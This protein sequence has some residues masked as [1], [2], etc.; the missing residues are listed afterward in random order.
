MTTTDRHAVDEAAVAAFAERIFGLYRDGLLV[1]MLDLGHRTGLF[2]AAASGPATSEALASRAGLDERYVREWL[3]AMATAGIVEYEPAAG[4]YRLPAEH[5]VCLTGGGSANLAP[6]AQ[7]I[8]HLAKHVGQ[9]AEA[10]RSGG[11]VPYSE[12]RP[13]FTSVM[14][15]LSRNFFDGALVDGVVPLVPGLADRLTSGARVAD[16]GCGTGHAMVVLAQ[17]FPRSTF[18]GY[19]IAVDAIDQ[20]RAEAAATG[21]ANAHFATCDVARLTVDEPFDVI[22]SFDAIHDQADPAAVLARIHDALVDS[23]TYVMME[24]AASS[25]LEDNLANPLAPFFYA[26]STMHCMTVSLAEGGAGLGTVWGEQLARHMLAEAGF[27][28]VVTHE[29]PDDPLDTIFVTT[30][31]PT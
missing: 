19:D 10:F 26:V 4:T 14:D 9:V 13:E 22:F 12:F 11:G 7:A 3:G 24:P 25:R 1:L 17:A 16:I 6:M 21:V 27:G 2:E 28:E 29:A 20:A 5:A 18:I 15:A 30:K 23:G 31:P 8:A